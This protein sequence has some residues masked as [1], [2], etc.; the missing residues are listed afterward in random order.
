MRAVA[1]RA[2]GVAS[3]AEILDCVHRVL[4][5]VD[6]AEDLTSRPQAGR[7]LRVT[8]GLGEHSVVKWYLEA[9]DFQREYDALR[10][11]TPS[12]G[13]DAPKLI[14]H[15]DALHM[16]LISHVPGSPVVGTAA[17]WDPLVH[18]KAGA[19]IRRLHESAPAVVSDQFARTCAARFEEAAS[20]L[21]NV[22]E[23]S[24]LQ[25][26]R[27]LIARAMDLESIP[28]VPTH[29]DNHPRNWMVDSGEHLR[30]IDFAD[31]EYDPWVVD[32]L[33]LEQHYWR[34]NP[35]LKIAFLGG[36]DRAMTDDDER[37]LRAHHA[38]AAA[39]ALADAQRSG[40]SKADKA[41]AK[42][43]FDRLVGATLF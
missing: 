34:S 31:C 36:Y 22:L 5:P 16:L 39:R 7:V 12:L 13:T 24:M 20:S 41:I 25:E 28:L 23:S 14:A 43:M 38:V 19:L 17:E 35:E 37:L 10:F 26:A 6:V 4:G 9:T 29:R 40:A 27:L 2:Q 8:T 15:D 18:Y 32:V 1:S 42:D 33:L 3:E 21:E 11:Y 30:L